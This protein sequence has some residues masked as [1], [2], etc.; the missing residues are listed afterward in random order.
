MDFSISSRTRS[1][2]F[3]ETLL[4]TLPT[5][6]VSDRTCFRRIAAWLGEQIEAGRFS[7]EIFPIVLSFASEATQPGVRNPAA[8][9][10]SIL[11]KE[12]GYDPKRM[13]H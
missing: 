8:V 9:F 12:L 1:L 13:R 10:V 5:R 6:T 11:K 7:E 3:Y 2:A 4:Q